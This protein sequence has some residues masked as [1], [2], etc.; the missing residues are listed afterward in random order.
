MTASVAKCL[1][2]ISIHISLLILAAKLA[3]KKDRQVVLILATFL[4][5]LGRVLLAVQWLMK[6]LARVGNFA[7]ACGVERWKK[8]YEL[9]TSRVIKY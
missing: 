2:Q 3:A 9:A 4:V 8:V 5:I 1:N 6:K 7:I